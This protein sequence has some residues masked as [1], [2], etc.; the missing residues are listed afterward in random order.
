[1]YFMSDKLPESLKSSLDYGSLTA[2]NF[3]SLSVEEKEEVLKMRNEAGIRQWMKNS[4]IISL[5]DHL[6]FIK[7]LEDTSR[8]FYWLVFEKLS[9]A[10]YGVIYVNNLNTVDQSCEFGIYGNP[11]LSK[12][13]GKGSLMAN[14]EL[15][16][17]FEVLGLRSV[18][19]EVHTAN[20][21]ALTLYERLGFKKIESADP[22]YMK[23]VLDREN[24]HGNKK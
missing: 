8:D 23:M 2:K 18:Y 13:K 4:G 19:L 3:I 5:Q 6:N 20:S 14:M 7:K 1:M 9:G 21:A 11:F 24:Y 15:Y 16:I 10:K 12:I 17:I 22:D